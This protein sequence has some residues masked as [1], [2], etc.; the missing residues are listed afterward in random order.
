MAFE[1]VAGLSVCYLA[2]AGLYI[3]CNVNSNNIYND[4]LQDPIYGYSDVVQNHLAVS[5]CVALH[6]DVFVS[7]DPNHLALPIDS[8][9][10]FSRMECALVS[11]C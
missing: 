3:F 6:V 10:I 8:Y 9:D 7:T 4:L 1:I 2:C 5:Q 11:L